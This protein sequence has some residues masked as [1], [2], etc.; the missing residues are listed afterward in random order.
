M[1]HTAK[2][3]EFFCRPDQR[4]LQ[5]YWKPAVGDWVDSRWFGQDAIGVIY[6]QGDMSEDHWAVALPELGTSRPNVHIH[7]LRWLPTLS[8]LLDM[9]EDRG[10]PYT[11]YSPDEEDEINFY[12]ITSWRKIDSEQNNKI[13]TIAAAEILKVAIKKEKKE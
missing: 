2:E 8:D 11:I 9:I 13:A 7:W 12:T 4:W 6:A 5:K 1:K 10:F 3:F